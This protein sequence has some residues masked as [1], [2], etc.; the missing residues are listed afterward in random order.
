[1]E[2]K[3]PLRNKAKEIVDYAIV[4][5]EDFINLNKYRWYKDIVCG[6]AISSIN[7]KKQRMHRHIMIDILKHDIDSHT[8]I[9]HINNN[10]L[11]NRRENLRVVS[12]SENSRNKSKTKN[13]TSEFFGVTFD[14]IRKMWRARLKLTD[15]PELNAYYN[16]EIHA[17]HQYNLWIEEHKVSCGKTNDIEIPSD[18][19]LY[20]PKSKQNE[21]PTCITY[22][23]DK[24]RYVVMV[25]KKHVGI[26]NSLEEAVKVRD[27]NKKELQ[28]KQTEER[29]N[30]QVL[31]NE[32]GLAIIQLFNKN[33]EK[34]NEVIVDDET[35]YELMKYK[36]W[37][38]GSGYVAAQLDNKKSILMHRYL[39]DYT[40]K[41]VVDHIN[42]NKLDNRKSNL[43]I[44]TRQ[45][46]SQNVTVCKNST[47]KYIGVCW[48]KECKKWSCQININGTKKHLGLFVD[49]IEAA[50]CRDTATKLYF[51]EHGKLN[52]F[53]PVSVKIQP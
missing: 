14:K 22:A 11:D 39:L 4:S 9:D 45:Q 5:K 31:R 38:S 10:R 46:N 3:I 40:G 33:K 8:P 32:D 1:M 43:R 27:E 26:Y 37:Y 25:N 42:G 48:A 13:S 17:A 18:F 6:Y 41:D 30:K 49:E 47:S 34:V 24:K 16:I 35:Y 36:W 28:D 44:V 50:K 20:N 2:Y 52:F 19:K 29:L 53:V 12:H 15:K 51:G 23:R 21:L 7:K